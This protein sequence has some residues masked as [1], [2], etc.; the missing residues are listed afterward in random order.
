MSNAL[1]IVRSL[2]IY[3]LCLPLAIILGY[4]LAVPMDLTSFTIVLMAVFLPLVP[5]LLRWHHFFLIASWNFS[6]VLFFLPGRPNLW[7]ILTLVSLLLST[8]QYIL[9]RETKL[10][11]V[12]S[13]NRPL[14]FLF[15]VVLV[16]AV[17]A[18]GIG[19]RSFGNE[20]YG[21]KRYVVVLTAIIG[22][23]AISCMRIPR[24]REILYVSAFLLSGASSVI[25]CLGG[26]VDPSLY[27]IFA[28]F[29]V[30]S[31]ELLVGDLPDDMPIRLGG[32]APAAGA[33]IWYGLARYGLRD[34][35]QMGGSWHFLPL[36]FH[37]GFQLN[38]P[39]R[40]GLMLLALWVA[41]H[42]GFRSSVAFFGMMFVAH[43]F[44]EGLHRSRAMP[45][46][47]LMGIMTAAI[48]LPF[49]SKMPVTV[50]RAISFL[51]VEIDPVIRMG[52]ESSTEWRLRMWQ[53]VLPMVPRYLLVGK[54]YSINPAELAMSAGRTGVDSTE[55]AIVAGDYHNGPL[56]LLIPLGIWGALAFLW[57]L[58]AGFR[59]L[60]RNYRYG[61]PELARINTFLLVYFSVRV[62]FFFFIFGSFYNELYMFT[63]LVAM[64]ISVNGGLRGPVPV[65]AVK[66]AVGHLRLARV[67]P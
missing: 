38:Q 11:S 64:S 57:F 43:F 3:G 4:L 54:G 56:T 46:I 33:V 15:L 49:A 24:G 16:T 62:V 40:S 34:L 61:D 23:F 19:I 66:P 22:Y 42:A 45:L 41:L 53:L 55:T 35:L 58:G 12:P 30:E 52:A 32:L 21:G 17:L 51:P 28:I 44:V 13:V 60:H 1:A 9:Q 26:F 18:G 39:W 29:P 14:I 63:G 31:L 6:A 10:L 48:V 36:R 67:R 25:G 47:L 65:E 7:I 2:I 8:L 59:V 37:G 5:V 27:F 20:A 50:Q